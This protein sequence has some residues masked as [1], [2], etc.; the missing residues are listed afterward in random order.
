MTVLIITEMICGGTYTGVAIGPGGFFLGLLGGG[1]SFDC[2]C[3]IVLYLMSESIGMVMLGRM[4][5]WKLERDCRGR[6]RC[7]GRVQRTLVAG[8]YRGH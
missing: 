6:D 8:S 7:R 3:S 2:G 4:G 5:C 1:F